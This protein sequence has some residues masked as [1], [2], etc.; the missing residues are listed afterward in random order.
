MLYGR[1]VCGPLQGVED[2]LLDSDQ[3]EEIAVSQ[4]LQKL[5]WNL[6]KFMNLP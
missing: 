1:K 2:E 4:Y 5:K 6:K 3:V